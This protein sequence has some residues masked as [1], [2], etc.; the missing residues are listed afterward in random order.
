[1]TGPGVPAVTLSESQARDFAQRML[2]AAGVAPEKAL[3]VASVLT[4]ANLRGIDSHGLALLPHYLDQIEA[5]DLD[6]AAEGRVVSEC[7]ACLLY[8]GE[9]GLGAVTAQI[10]SAYAIRLARQYGIAIV[11]ARETN[12]F[13]PAAFWTQRIA[14]AGQIGIA[15]CDASQQV[16]PWQGKA[17]KIGTNP[18]SMAVPHPTGRGWLLDMATSTVALGKVEQAQLNR[19]TEIPD[20][21]AL[22][23]EG[24]PTNLLS[25]ALDGFLMPLGGYKGSGLGLMVE[26]LC[27]TLGGGAMSPGVRGIRQHGGPSRVNHTFLAID[28]AR[29]MPLD[30]FYERMDRLIGHVKSAPPAAGY[31]EVLVAGDPEWRY[32]DERRA[33]GI[34]ILPGPWETLERAARRL[35]VALPD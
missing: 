1:M 21:W 15:V 14:A 18:I 35:G 13:G 5:G 34:P 11:V 20:G 7:Q 6:P 8:D 31:D 4:Y 9:H 3:A 25:A 24:R 30:T 26:I 16:P 32:E 33:H 29:F 2:E 22:D 12:H 19:K 23:S 17:R 10:C 27:G 28:V